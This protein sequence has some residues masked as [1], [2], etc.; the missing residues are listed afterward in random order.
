MASTKTVRIETE[1][2]DQIGKLANIYSTVIGVE[3]AP[4]TPTF[5]LL[6]NQSFLTS[7]EDDTK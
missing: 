5:S 1:L 7:S 4:Q 2:M 6:P 3:V